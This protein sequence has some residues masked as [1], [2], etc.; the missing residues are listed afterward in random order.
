MKPN[1]DFFENI[2]KIEIVSQ[3]YQKKRENPNKVRIGEEIATD[4]KEIQKVIIEYY[5]QLYANKLYNLEE[6]TKILESWNL[7]TLNK[8]EID[9]LS[10]PITRNEIEFVI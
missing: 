1:V 2:D 3:T 5:K 7:P 9:N 6:M 4:I 10:K 8:E